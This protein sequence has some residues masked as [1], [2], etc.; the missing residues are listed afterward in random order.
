MSY[1]RVDAFLLYLTDNIDSLMGKGM[2][3]DEIVKTVRESWNEVP[4][5]IKM[6]YIE[7]E[8]KI[9]MNNRDNYRVS[10]LNFYN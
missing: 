7:K 8:I 6:F 10:F 4:R 1:E 5:E 9:L 2:S 3:A